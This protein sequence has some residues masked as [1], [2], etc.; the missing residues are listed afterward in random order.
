LRPGLRFPI[1]APR[2]FPVLFD[3]IHH[4]NTNGERA[5]RTAQAVRYKLGAGG[6]PAVGQ[7]LVELLN[8]ALPDPREHV[9]EPG[10]RVHLR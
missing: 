4:T 9:L 1:T 5:E 2:G 10:E 7:Q 6:G 8:R 3:R